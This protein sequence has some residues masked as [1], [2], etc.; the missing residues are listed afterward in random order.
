MDDSV[1]YIRDGICCVIIRD[2]KGHTDDGLLGEPSISL[3]SKYAA[4]LFRATGRVLEILVVE[5]RTVIGLIHFA[6]VRLVHEKPSA[7]G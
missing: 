6:F 2:V 1:A 3:L 4:S 7:L 5:V